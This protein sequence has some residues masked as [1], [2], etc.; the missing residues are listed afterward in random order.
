MPRHA[1]GRGSSWPDEHGRQKIH[2]SKAAGPDGIW[3]THVP[4]DPLYT[5]AHMERTFKAALAHAVA[6]VDGGYRLHLGRAA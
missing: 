1:D 2:V 6:A 5:V 3:Y 4:I